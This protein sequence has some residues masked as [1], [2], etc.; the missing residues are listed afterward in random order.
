MPIKKSMKSIVILY[1]SKSEYAEKKVFDGKSALEKTLDWA[2][3]FA[4]EDNIVKIGDCSSTAEVLE[5]IVLSAQE[6]NADYII[7]SFDDLP[8]INEEITKK[9]IEQ[10][11]KYHAEY[12]FSDGYPAGFAPEII[13]AQAAAIMAKLSRTNLKD[14]G[15]KKVSRSVIYDFIKNDINSFDVETFI[16]PHDWRLLRFSFNTACKRDFLSCKALFNS[17]QD[18]N[19]LCNADKLAEAASKNVAVLKTLPAYYNI[20]I[21]NSV[22]TNAIYNPA[23]TVK[24]AVY[25][26]KMSYEDFASLTKRISE[27]SEDAVISLSVYGEPFVHSQIMQIIENVLSY[28][29]FSLFLETDGLN[30]TE[31]ICSKL[32]ELLA[33]C[34]KAKKNPYPK[35]MIAVQMD[36]FTKEGYAK[37]HKNGDFEKVTNAIS[38]LSSYLPGSVYPQFIR[39]NENEE[40]LES[41][42][43]YWNEKT[44]PAGGNFIIQK[45]D[46]FA[47]LLPERKPAD[48]SPLERN[49]CW[50]LRR[51]MTILANGDVCLCRSCLFENPLGNVFKEDLESIWHKSDCIVSNHVENKLNEKCGKCDEFYTFNF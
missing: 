39:M 11:I 46:N 37:I 13:N 23:L 20:Q 26:E 35:L 42:F 27:F 16:A 2:S 21:C 7:F 36:A 43:R 38:L 41:F 47:G 34:P 14:A 32:K 24:D 45:Y 6:K 30:I 8:F 10:H 31:E 5:K 50:H 19:D 18:K 44:S 29:E 49:V 9:L 15:E 40:E 33:S 1:E 51:D 17:I 25:D 12:T 4:E 48:L 22:N 3:L 28:P